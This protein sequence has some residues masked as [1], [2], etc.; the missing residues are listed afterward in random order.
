[1]NPAS[2]PVPGFDSKPAGVSLVFGGDFCPIRGYERKM[3]AGEDIFSPELKVLF[4]D[5]VSVINLE[6][7]LCEETLPTPSPSG[8][9]LRGSPAIAGYL[10]NLGVDAWGLANNHIR[11]FG[12]EGVRQTIGNLRAAGLAT[13]GAGEN[14]VAAG[15]PLELQAHG[16]RVGLWAIAE[17][18][19]NLAHATRPGAA[20]FLPDQNIA[21]IQKLREG[22]DFFVVYVHAGHEFTT[23]PSPRIRSAYRAFVEAGADAVIGHHPH[24]VQGVEK[25]MGGL[26]AYSLGNLVF[27]SPYVSAYKTTDVGFLLKM[28]IG[29]HRIHQAEVIPYRLGQDFVVAPLGEGDFQKFRERFTGLSQTIRQEGKYLAEW[30]NNVRFRWETEYRRILTDFSKNFADRTN[31]DFPRR[32][33]NLFTC[34]THVEMLEK[35]FFMMEDPQG[36]LEF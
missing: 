32:A 35:I 1:M 2:F 28:D 26:V 21:E 12:D 20:C 25:Y 27:D 23:V 9:G 13:F 31:P 22:Y 7:P 33:R 5:H 18:E 30:E 6:S 16:L 3:L 10:K 8:S 17:K 14:R 19:L 4:Q 29:K 24:V 36:G 11:D 15:K 34:P